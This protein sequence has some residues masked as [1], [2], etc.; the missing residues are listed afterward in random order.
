MKIG[1]RIHVCHI[2]LGYEGDGPDVIDDGTVISNP[3]NGEVDVLI[4]EAIDGKH[5]FHVYLH[6]TTPILAFGD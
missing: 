4:D 5:L 3:A 6:E 1:D 2:S